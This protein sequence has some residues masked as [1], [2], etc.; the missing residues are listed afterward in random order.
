MP[1]KSLIRIR[2]TLQV[3]A[4][5]SRSGAWV[6]DSR[7]DKLLGD[8]VKR[9]SLKAEK[10]SPN[11]LTRMTE[12]LNEVARVID[13]LNER[14][15]MNDKLKER[16]LK[17]KTLNETALKAEKDPLYTLAELL[18][19][20][21]YLYSQ[22][23]QSHSC[24]E[25]K[26]TLQD[27]E[28]LDDGVLMTLVANKAIPSTI[29]GT[30]LLAGLKFCRETDPSCSEFL[31]TPPLIREAASRALASLPA[32]QAL[33]DYKG[34]PPSTKDLDRQLALSLA[35]YW[36]KHTSKNPSTGN[37]AKS[38]PFQ[39][40]AAEMFELVGRRSN[41]K[42]NLKGSA[43]QG[44]LVRIDAILRQGIRDW[45]KQDFKTILK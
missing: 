17:A 34:G 16:T 45:K 26:R 20:W 31:W 25:F 33:A 7:P 8:I 19:L 9:Y 15:L 29:Y 12:E 6:R 44:A 32:N 28:T 30:I 1:S 21:R 24:G 10:T 39:E 27:L 14:A 40:F 2:G 38:S 23:E 18:Q 43:A 3:E 41:R 5:K 13:R 35:R 42:P 4:H 37:D 22:L 11:E 36:K